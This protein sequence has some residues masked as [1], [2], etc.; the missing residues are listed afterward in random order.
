VQRFR[1]PPTPGAFRV[2][3]AVNHLVEAINIA[4]PDREAVRRALDAMGRDLD[5][6]RHCSGVGYG[7][8]LVILGRL[9]A[10]GWNLHTISDL[11]LAAP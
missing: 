9:G 5:G 6:E 2:F 10:G 3:E 1:R 4:G 7:P 11:G 8:D